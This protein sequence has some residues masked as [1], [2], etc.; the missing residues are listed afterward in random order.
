MSANQRK[1]RL[2]KKESYKYMTRL[3]WDASYQK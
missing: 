1:K 2:G 3:G